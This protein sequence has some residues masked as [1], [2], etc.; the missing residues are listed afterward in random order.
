MHDNDDFGFGV[1]MCLIVI[2]ASVAVTT[3]ITSAYKT[4]KN[5]VWRQAV[6]HGYAKETETS[7]GK[8]YI[9]NR[10]GSTVSAE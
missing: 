5:E 4:G 9:W 2:I 8:V 3:G 7:A 10:T 6:E 1:I